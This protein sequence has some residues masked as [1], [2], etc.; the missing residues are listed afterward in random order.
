MRAMRRTAAVALTLV[1]MVMSPAG[2]PVY[3][4]PTLVE[5]ATCGQHVPAHAMGFLSADLDC[6]SVGGPAGVYLGKGAKLD[7]R[8]FTL[9]VGGPVN[10]ACEPLVYC[11]LDGCFSKSG[12]C[13]VFGGRL[14]G[15]SHAAIVGGQVTIRDVAI[16]NHSSYAVL[17]QRRI[18]VFDS[19]IENAPVGLQASERVTIVGSSMVVAAA[20]AK[21]VELISSSITLHPTEGVV[22][23][24]VRL[25]DSH[26]TGNGT[27]PG[28]ATTK[29]CS[30]LSTHKIPRLDATSTCDVSWKEDADVPGSW[31]VCALD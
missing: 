28:C 30:D 31:G 17:A 21:R 27:D 11:S 25:I 29:I 18:D 8:G 3:G 9:T 24:Y 20:Q 2:A 1:A 6:A 7:L 19:H 23:W 22:A 13:E 14:V 16:E 12:K 5:V 4:A 10:V 26:V 15:S